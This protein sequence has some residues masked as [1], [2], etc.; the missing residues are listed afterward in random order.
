MTLDLG[1]FVAIGAIVVAFALGWRTVGVASAALLAF[2]ALAAY[3]IIESP[4][5]PAALVVVMTAL[6]CSSKWSGKSYRHSALSLLRECAL[7][8]TA[9]AI[10]T[11]L[12]LIESE[13]GPA[14]ANAE[15]IVSLERT[16]NTFFEPTVQDWALNSEA[17]VRSLNWVYSFAFL[18]IT[19]AAMIWLWFTDSKNYVLLRNV[20]GASAL[21]AI[22]TIIAFPAAPPRLLETSGMVDTITL[23]GREHAYA[24]EY[25]ALPSLHVGWMVAVGYAVGLSVGGRRGLTIAVLPGVLMMATVIVTGNHF[26]LD[27]ALG[28]L[29]ALGPALALSGGLALLIAKSTE[30]AAP[31]P[32]AI[33]NGL[34]RLVA[35]LENGRVRF[36]ALALGSLL[37]YLIINQIENPGFTNFWGYLVAQVAVILTLL[38]I[39]EFIFAKSGGLSWLTHGVAVACCFADVLGTDGNLYNQID[40][41]DKLT[42]YL[43]IAAVTAGVY[44]CL[45][46]MHYSGWISQ[47]PR[48]RLFMA[49][50]IGVSAGVAWEVYEL[51]GDKVF[52]TARVYGPWDTG[53]DIVSNTAGALSV[54]VLLWMS[55]RR[56]GSR[57]AGDELTPVSGGSRT[58]EL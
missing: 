6:A 8:L 16:L 17:L 27:G 28:T 4:A 47:P 22:V 33:G 39:G 7:V 53:N 10:Y 30:L 52:N 54:A 46:G 58:W 35:V 21:L 48:A 36:S 37:I 25:A 40:E 15:R 11:A 1:A 3:V 38:V 9:L 41:Y 42:H 14:A 2:L 12:R 34:D 29:F 5:I 55:E 26:W 49:V 32:G 20:L 18:A 51:L 23:Y 56:L 31:S 13:P 45:R 19:A 57:R 24:N 50:A 44:D 43:G